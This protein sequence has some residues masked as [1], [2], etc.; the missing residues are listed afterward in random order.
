[1]NVDAEHTI[2]NIAISQAQ[3]E[4]EQTPSE[5]FLP[6]KAGG[7]YVVDQSVIAGMNANLHDPT[8][9]VDSYSSFSCPWN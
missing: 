4:V 9:M 2:S 6:P 8:T 3:R 5:P 1:M 7:S